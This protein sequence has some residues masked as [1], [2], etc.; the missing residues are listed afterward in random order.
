MHPARL[1]AGKHYS[2]NPMETV[3]KVA[4][5]FREGGFYL[6]GRWDL[7]LEISNVRRHSLPFT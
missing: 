5:T 4:F 6:S 1:K 3:K 7:L 2:A